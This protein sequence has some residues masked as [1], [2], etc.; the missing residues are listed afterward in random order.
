MEGQA[1]EVLL[2][3]SMSNVHCANQCHT[4]ITFATARIAQRAFYRDSRLKH[5]NLLRA[6]DFLPAGRQEFMPC[7][8]R[9]RFI[10]EELRLESSQKP[11]SSA[12]STMSDCI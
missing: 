10:A 2:A 4:V 12:I 8:L 6:A 9:R 11:S 1:L 3:V 5:G 7:P